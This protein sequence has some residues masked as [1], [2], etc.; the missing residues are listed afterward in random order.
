M[1]IL[2]IIDGLVVGVGIF[3][4]LFTILTMALWIR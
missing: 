3:A 2:K 1:R 4:V